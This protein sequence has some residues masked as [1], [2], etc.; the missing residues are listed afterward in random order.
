MFGSM[1]LVKHQ[2][3]WCFVI[4]LCE[5]EVVLTYRINA[6]NH[7]MKIPTLALLNNLPLIMYPVLIVV[8]T[9]FSVYPGGHGMESK[10]S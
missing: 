4:I 8:A 6:D 9:V 2:H 7:W 1:F 10:L 5:T 3:I